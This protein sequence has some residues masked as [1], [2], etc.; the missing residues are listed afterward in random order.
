MKQISVRMTDDEGQK[1]EQLA[2][3]DGRSV[4][5]YVR[6]VLQVH[7]DQSTPSNGNAKP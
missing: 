5:N 7:I 2:E 1:V 4:T 6:R 3:A